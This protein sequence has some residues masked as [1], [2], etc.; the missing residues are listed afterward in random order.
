MTITASPPP[1]QLPSAAPPPLTPRRRTAV[2]ASLVIAASVLVVSCVVALG[3]T[4]W[5]LSGYRVIADE[6]TL[7]ADLKSLIIDVGNVPTAVRLTIEDDATVPRVSMRLINLDR[8]GDHTLDVT[9]ESG[10]ARVT[11]NGQGSGFMD[12]GRAGKITV[13]LPREIARRLSVTAQLEDGVLLAEADLDS[14]VVHNVD[15]AVILGGSARNLEIH[16]RDGSIVAHEPIAVSESFLAAAVDGDVNVD[17]VS[18][19]PRRLE[20]TTRDG[21]VK[22]SLPE[23]GPYLVQAS[24]DSTRVSVPRTNDRARAVAEVSVRTA[25]GNIMIDTLDRR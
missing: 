22:I 24:G 23:P 21:D 18:A 15:G 8:S 25:D 19:P 17:F 13:T 14:L 1:P 12:W 11:V 6:K 4:A 3:M 2:R 10:T 9:E 20:A 7:Q 5:G 16:T